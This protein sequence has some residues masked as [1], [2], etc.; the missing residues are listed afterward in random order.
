MS[1]K[2]LLNLRRFTY[3]SFIALWAI[4]I[5]LIRTHQFHF[6]SGLGWIV[7]FVTALAW[8][9]FGTIALFWQHRRKMNPPQRPSGYQLNWTPDDGMF[10]SRETQ[11]R[12]RTVTMRSHQQEMSHWLSSQP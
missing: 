8:S 11:F 5:Y 10:A 4:A 2:Y 6:I 7:Y 12:G 1:S 9:T 3:G